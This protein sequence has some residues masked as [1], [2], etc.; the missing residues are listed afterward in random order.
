MF[1][2]TLVTV[3]ITKG[4]DA[5]QASRSQGMLRTGETRLAE[6]AVHTMVR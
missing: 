4:T 2:T 3:V 6:D 5:V 1:I